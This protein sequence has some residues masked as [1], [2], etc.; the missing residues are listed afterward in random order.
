MQARDKRLTHWESAIFA[1]PQIPRANARKRIGREEKVLGI[2]N[3]VG[4]G[5]EM[6]GDHGRYQLAWL[7]PSFI[8]IFLQLD[9]F[10]Q[11]V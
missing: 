2:K 11:A 10:L 5:S 9:S 4:F 6:L 3:T 1:C 8:F 7:V